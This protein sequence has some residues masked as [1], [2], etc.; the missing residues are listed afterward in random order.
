MAIFKW[1]DL[2][3]LFKKSFKIL[4]K[5]APLRL[6][7]S[8]AFFTIFA[9]PPIILIITSVFG[10]IFNEEIISGEL[11]ETLKKIIGE[12]SAAAV[13]NILENIQH[14]E[15]NLLITILG[16]LFLIFIS[17]TLFKVIQ[18]SLNQIWQIKLKKSRD[19]KHVLKSRF[20]SF[21]LIIFGGVLFLISLLLDSALAYSK[22]YIA[23]IIPG[24]DSFLIQTA[25]RLVTFGVLIIGL[26]IIFKFLSDAHLFWKP[27]IAGAVL[28]AVLFTIGEVILGKL[29]INSG[30]GNIYGT[31]AAI[32]LFLLFV[33]Y[34]SF[35]FYFG[36]T[37]TKCY[38]EYCDKAIQ[39]KGYATFYKVKDVTPE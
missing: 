18:S 10:F 13:Y 3:A 2:P 28:T 24:L 35:I 37:F 21:S 8:T 15:K 36:A 19:L 34:S 1:K 27:V 33:F 38:A 9:L 30:L 22:D 23:E 12:K 20:I 17:T 32:V 14:I 7:A 11:F 16:F 25:R 5:N 39:P 29:L 6:G 4:M 31:A 26:S